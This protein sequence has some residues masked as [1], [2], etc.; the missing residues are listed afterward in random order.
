MSDI[1]ELTTNQYVINDIFFNDILN[2]LT[3]DDNG[4]LI[5]NPIYYEI[6]DIFVGLCNLII[7]KVEY[8]DKHDINSF[9]NSIENN[10][11][12]SNLS[13]ILSFNV[14]PNKYIELKDEKSIN[15]KMYVKF[16]E[17]LKPKDL[18]ELRFDS[19]NIFNSIFQIIKNI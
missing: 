17:E 13:N 4:I 2:V 18:I 8:I 14:Y 5:Y 10:E 7:Q 3:Y 11:P 9:F 1:K 6:I 15:Q 19:N 12:Y 16:F